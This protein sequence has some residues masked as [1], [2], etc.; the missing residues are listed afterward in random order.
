MPRFDIR[1]DVV[2]QRGEFVETVEHVGIHEDEK[3]KHE[4]ED[5]EFD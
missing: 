5:E 1:F 3:I 4:E 2:L